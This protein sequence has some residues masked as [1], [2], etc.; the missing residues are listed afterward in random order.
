MESVGWGKNSAS[1]I[2]VPY[3]ISRM[4]RALA[5]HALVISFILM[6]VNMLG[7]K[8]S[9]PVSHAGQKLIQLC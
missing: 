3:K 4:A 1:R 7:Q 9:S 2:V 6:I 5:E 8:N